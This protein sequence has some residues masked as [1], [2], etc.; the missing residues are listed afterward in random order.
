MNRK[1]SRIERLVMQIQSAF[2][3]DSMLAVTLPAVQRRFGIDE[4]TSVG[5]LDALVDARVLTERE[6]VYRRNV[7]RSTVRPAA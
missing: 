7:P 6:G 4:F 1:R 5:L 3:E 2:L